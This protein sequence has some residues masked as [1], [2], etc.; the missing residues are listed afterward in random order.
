MKLD[1]PD[2]RALML[3]ANDCAKRVLAYFEEMNPGVDRPRNAIEAER[4]WA[5]GGLGISEARDGGPD[6]PLQKVGGAA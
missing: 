1:G 2:H 6:H 3:W 4:A 5:R